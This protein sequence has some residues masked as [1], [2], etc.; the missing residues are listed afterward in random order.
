VGHTAH[1]IDL[2]CVCR[3]D[4][5]YNEK[6]KVPIRRV[7]R[8]E[9]EVAI[10]P[11]LRYVLK[12]TRRFHQRFPDRDLYSTRFVSFVL[13]VWSLEISHAPYTSTKMYRQ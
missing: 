4:T 2:A 8:T 5:P 13:F 1:L 3:Y 9:Y 11:S 12:V 7:L 10:E 6:D